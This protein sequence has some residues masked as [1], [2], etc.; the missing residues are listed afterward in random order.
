MSE[1]KYPNSGALFVN[2]RKTKESHPDM[3][4]NG[5]IHGIETWISGW[6]KQSKNGKSFISLSFKAKDAVTG[7]VKETK[8]NISAHEED[9]VPF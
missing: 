2:D 3:T 6:N 8:L 1:N 9:S 5:E 4:G 7:E